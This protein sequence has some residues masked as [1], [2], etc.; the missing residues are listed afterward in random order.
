[1]RPSTVPPEEGSTHAA[2]PQVRSEGQPPRLA[3]PARQNATMATILR[4][5]KEV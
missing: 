1:M 3:Q 5:V 4:M 2:A